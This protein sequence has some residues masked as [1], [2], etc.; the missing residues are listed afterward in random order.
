MNKLTINSILSIAVLLSVPTGTRAQG[1][2]YL[3]NLGATSNG[4]LGIGSDSWAAME[5]VTGPSSDG[6]GLDSIQLAMTEASG[7]PGGFS[8]MI[9]SDVGVGSPLPGS[10]LGSLSGS[11]SPSTAG[12]YAYTPAGDLRLS[13][14]TSYFFVVTAGSPVADG[15]YQWSD[16]ATSSYSLSGGWHG[17]AYYH[18][19]DGSSWNHVSGVY[20]IFAINATPESNV[21]EPSVI[22]LLVLGGL[23]LAGRRILT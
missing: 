5:F 13:R 21:P 10:S 11:P 19:T 7:S 8:V 22:S 6:Y 2:T 23:C 18:S 14:T 9:Y 16:A 20:P 17:T 15:A 3:S 4:S 12:V 1:T